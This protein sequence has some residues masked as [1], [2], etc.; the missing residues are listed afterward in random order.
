MDAIMH[1]YK[2][3]S[4]IILRHKIFQP[5]VIMSESEITIPCEGQ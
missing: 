4:E 5:T 2:P 3:I 1:T